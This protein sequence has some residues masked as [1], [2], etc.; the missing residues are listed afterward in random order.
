MPMLPHTTHKTLKAQPTAPFFTASSLGIRVS[1][2]TK[3][4]CMP[5][6]LLQFPL[7]LVKAAQDSSLLTQQLHLAHKLGPQPLRLLL[8]RLQL[9]QL[10]AQRLGRGGQV[11]AA[12]LLQ[13]EGEKQCQ[14]RRG[15]IKTFA[16]L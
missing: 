14:Q 16:R 13:S 15:T 11:R 1:T 12:D 2:H 4:P 3:A 5:H 9:L 7:L 8:L 10:R 6:L